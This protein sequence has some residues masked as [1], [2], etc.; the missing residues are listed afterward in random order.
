M[1]L[2]FTVLIFAGLIQLAALSQDISSE[3]SKVSGNFQMDG[4]YTQSDTLIGA[5][6]KPEKFLSNS[7]FYMNYTLGNFTAGMRY[8]AYQ[9]TILGIDPR[10]NGS[11][12]AY[13][14][15]Q[16]NNDF[17][18]ITAGNF[19]EQFGS[20][21]I[22]RA[23]EERNLGVDNSID[24]VKAVFT[25]VKGIE[26]KGLIG[27]QRSFWTDGAG[28]LRAGDINIEINN[29]VQNLLPNDL[30]VAVGGGFV[31]RYQAANDS[32]Y[33]FPENVMAYSTR[34]SVNGKGFNVDGEFS[35]KVNDPN[36]T[37][38]YSYNPGTGLIINSS[39]FGDGF[40]FSLN[41]HRIDNMDFRSD[42]DVR[43]L[44]LNVSYIP[45]L[46]KQQ[47]YRLATLYPFSTQFNGEE[48]LQADFTYTVPKGSSLGGNYGT[49]INLN[50]SRIQNLDT[51]WTQIDTTKN[52]PFKY[53]S[54]FFKIGKRL[55]YQ[56]LSL[57]INKK[58]SS[59]FKSNLS[60]VN[61]IY[62][63]DIVEND[64]LPEFGKVY[65][66]AAILELQYKFTSKNT[67]R[68]EFQHLWSIQ[69][70]TLLTPN[71]MNGNWLM[72]LA[73][74]TTAPN[75]FISLYD[76]YNYGNQFEDYKLHYLNAAV[77][78]ITGG[79]RVSVGYGRQRGGLLCVGGICR[80]V[81]ASLGATLS[82][83]SAF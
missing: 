47:V 65:A 1:K 32:Y 74:Y 36:A 34:A 13:R 53:D 50:Y 59:I 67:L 5:K 11:G 9:P 45:P 42:R 15:V 18:N 10:Y 29:V 78:F 75:W 19:Y 14:F 2:F 52:L 73:E 7:Y 3:I 81:P 79:T 39:F 70:S 64:G 38:K 40:G 8:E 46:T 71:N 48:G 69:D 25:P 76:E 55:Y 17:V 41:L 61:T 23:Y 63:K 30:Q 43:G 66:T 28:T 35:Y 77:A 83:T 58:W 44:D 22:L 16:F 54:P 20:G 27:K 49:T 33:Y 80:Q 24:G 31:S 26:V 37:N 68:M 6:V 62:D 12:I 60:I 21:M 57:E 51:T 4:Q 82:I 72:A 56:E